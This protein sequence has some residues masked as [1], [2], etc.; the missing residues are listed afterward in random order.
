MERIWSC[1]F[2]S[3][4]LST[5]MHP[6]WFRFLEHVAHFEPYIRCIS[7]RGMNLSSLPICTKDHIEKTCGWRFNPSYRTQIE[8]CGSK[9][10]RSFY[11]DYAADSDDSALNFASYFACLESYRDTIAKCLPLLIENCRKR[12]IRLIKAVRAPMSLVAGFLDQQPNFKLIH[13]LRDPLGVVLS[14]YVNMWSRG[15]YD[16]GE[17]DFYSRSAMSYCRRAYRD[18]MERVQLEKRYPGRILT[19]IFD[20]FAND[21]ENVMKKAFQ[22]VGVR[23]PAFNK[24][25]EHV[26]E[27]MMKEHLRIDQF[28]AN[29]KNTSVKWHQTLPSFVISQIKDRCK[30]FY[31]QVEF[32]WNY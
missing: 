16:F 30:E 10:A 6:F 13:L 24:T 1:D 18:I 32:G 9:M 17:V 2:A 27:E 21:P 5:L 15:F 26:S 12:P 11:H 4:P 22:F 25:V 3:L 7:E 14:R 31:K 28:L 29:L 19:L 20:Q 8:F 23:M